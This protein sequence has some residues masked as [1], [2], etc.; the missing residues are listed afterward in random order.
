MVRDSRRQKL[1]NAERA[2]KWPDTMKQWGRGSVPEMRAYVDKLCRSAWF[3]RR[4]PQ[5]RVYSIQVRDG[6]GH[7]NA[8]GGG[9]VVQ[10]PLWARK[11]WVLLH[12]VAHCVTGTGH[13]HDW[14]FCANYLA[15]VHHQMGKDA[16]DELRAQFKFHRVK[17]TKPRA[18]RP[19]TEEQKAILRERLKV[20]R[21][22]KGKG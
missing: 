9:G 16:A 4:W 18:K 7:R 1:Y 12:E 21:A 15:L 11:E 3:V 10:M 13:K 22:A 14:M 2:A 6:R 17:Y 20:A 5:F 19:M 8:T